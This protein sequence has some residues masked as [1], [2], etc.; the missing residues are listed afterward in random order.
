MAVPSYKPPTGCSS[1]RSRPSS[2]IVGKNT[3]AYT[4]R[5]DSYCKLDG[6]SSKTHLIPLDS[7]QLCDVVYEE[8][9]GKKEI[10]KTLSK[11]SIRERKKK[12]QE[13]LLEKQVSEINNS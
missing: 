8:W 1:T 2:S 4:S 12:E 13:M 11:K 6:D 3:D 7:H 5:S 9:L 10:E